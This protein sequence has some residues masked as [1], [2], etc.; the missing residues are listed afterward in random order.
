MANILVFQPRTIRRARTGC[1]VLLVALHASSVLG[2]SVLD[3]VVG[4]FHEQPLT[5]NLQPDGNFVSTLAE[6]TGVPMGFEMAP[7][8]AH[9]GPPLRVPATGKRL[10]DVLDAIVNADPRYEWREEAGVVVVR[11]VEAWANTSDILAIPVGPITLENANREDVL[12][13]L[14]QIFGANNQEPRL[15]RSKTFS[16]DVPEGTP[17]LQ[18]L[19]AVVRAHGTLSWKLSWLTGPG[20]PPH[21]RVLSL[22][23]EFGGWGFGVSLN[24]TIHPGPY[25]VRQAPPE[26]TSILVPVLDRVV[27]HTDRPLRISSI[28]LSSVFELARAVGVPMGF[29]IATRNGAVAPPPSR[30]PIDVS[31]MVLR[32]ALEQVSRLDPRFEW[33][34]M[35]GVIVFRPVESW[36]DPQDPLSRSIPDVSLRDVPISVA[37]RLILSS[38]GRVEA[39]LTLNEKKKVSIALRQATVL[40]LLNATAQSHGE[41]AWEWGNIPPAHRRPEWQISLNY[42]H[43]VRFWFFDPSG[44]PAFDVP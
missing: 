11:P 20:V 39:A 31:G 30:E 19:N 25:V 17:L 14:L 43:T 12:H 6:V 10:R 1:V 22:L 13:V 27:G 23:G 40:D 33:R 3:R 5:I 41:L 37:V 18:L 26:T 28:T 16:L 9:S 24:E 2:Q 35:N 34:E 21:T 36:S 4:P 42:R 44:G 15:R 32:D 8:E 38:F 7:V 29:Q